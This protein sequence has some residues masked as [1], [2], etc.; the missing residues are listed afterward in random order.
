MNE[1]NST[2]LLV[3]AIAA[4]AAF[5]LTRRLGKAGKASGDRVREKIKAGARI[6][7]VRT[8]E[9]YSHGAY[10]KAKNIP[11][12]VLQSRLDSLGPKDKPIVLY[13]A[14][15]SRSAQAARLL[16]QAGF[17]DVNNAGG[18]GEMPR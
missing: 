6:V 1:L 4:I 2:S 13:C 12:D 11:L 9:E 7:D 14:S 8:P 17:T 15:G 18:F 16:R 5:A 3:M 10:P